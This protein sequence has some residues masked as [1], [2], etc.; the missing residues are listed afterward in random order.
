MSRKYGRGPVSNWNARV[1]QDIA[2][3][4]WKSSEWGA[5]AGMTLPS[6]V[7]IDEL[8][9]ADFRWKGGMSA[10]SSRK[11]VIREVITQVECIL[12][13]CG[14]DRIAF[15]D[16][17]EMG[18][19]GAL[20]FAAPIAVELNVR[21]SLLRPWRELIGASVKGEQPEPGEEFLIFTDVVNAGDTILD[22]LETLRHFGAVAR[23]AYAIIDRDDNPKVTERRVTRLG[24]A[25]KLYHWRKASQITPP[26]ISRG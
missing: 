11:A 2:A 6:Y 5:H 20:W 25:V 24:T 19:V 13:E 18:P 9:T 3:A 21:I 1:E 16:E 14:I 4:I 15:V 17:G 23:A 22:A 8:F 26:S 7:D 12:A 10:V